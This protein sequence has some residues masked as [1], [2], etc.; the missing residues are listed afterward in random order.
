MR[1][2]FLSATFLAVLPVTALAAAPFGD[3]LGWA[4]ELADNVLPNDNVYGPDPEVAYAGI[5]GTTYTA[6]TQCASFL[7]KM[8]E[9]AYDLDYHAW[10]KCDSPNARTYYEHIE[11][12][13]RFDILD[14]VHDLQA[15]DIFATMRLNC[16]NVSC[17]VVEAS[18]PVSGHMAV[19]TGAPVKMRVPKAPY[20]TG[21][22][23]YEL[24]VVDSTSD[25]HGT[26]DSR[27]PN[28]GGN[29]HGV[30]YG[31][32]RVYAMSDGTIV[33]Y[34][35]ST[36]TGSTYYDASTRPVL[37]ARYNPRSGDDAVWN[38]GGWLNF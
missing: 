14:N 1:S 19:L 8:M 9:R 3:H 2:I 25:V 29:G 32:M 16:S 24:Y 34:T 10:M 17:G 11:A 37:F 18:C 12:E 26:S 5:D 33:G 7:T 6:R 15:G 31:T 13:D 27:H 36:L 28:N 23:Q 22:D 30:G 4:I 35:W 20:Q 38:G 21:L